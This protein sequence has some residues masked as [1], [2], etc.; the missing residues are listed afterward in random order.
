MNFNSNHLSQKSACILSLSQPREEKPEMLQKECRGEA[1]D[2]RARGS[3]NLLSRLGLSTGLSLPR[4]LV[5]RFI[6]RPD[7]VFSGGDTVRAGRSRFAD[8]PARE[9]FADRYARW[10]RA[11]RALKHPDKLRPC[12]VSAFESHCTLCRVNMRPRG[13]CSCTRVSTFSNLVYRI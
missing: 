6:C 13:P 5:S 7:P 2:R 4:C 9:I 11:K 3:L 12:S 10:K 8:P 1:S